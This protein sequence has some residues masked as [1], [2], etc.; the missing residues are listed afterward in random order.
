MQTTSFGIWTQ[1]SDSIFSNNNC[2]TISISNPSDTGNM[3]TNSDSILS[4]APEIEPHYKMQF[5]EFTKTLI[6]IYNSI[7]K[8]VKVLCIYF[9]K[10]ILWS[11]V[12]YSWYRISSMFYVF[13][14]R[15]RKTE[16][17]NG[18]IKSL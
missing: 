16:F 10:L 5:N 1:I 7:F 4:N 6:E 15:K 13:N 2:Y 12:I 17:V 9:V 14:E 11:H 18:L 3:A 8:I